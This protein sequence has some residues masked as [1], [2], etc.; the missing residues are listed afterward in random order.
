MLP[1]VRVLWAPREWAMI[2]DL[3]SLKAATIERGVCRARAYAR[4]P[5]TFA[6][7]LPVQ[8]AALLN[9]LPRKVLM[10][11]PITPPVWMV[12]GIDWMMD[13]GATL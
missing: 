3:V 8:V 2:D 9:T 7:N 5:N 11:V 10:T 1:L 12:S 13:P 4:D 6:A